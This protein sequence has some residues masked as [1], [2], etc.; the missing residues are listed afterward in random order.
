VG[1]TT[2]AGASVLPRAQHSYTQAAWHVHTVS[3]WLSRLTPVT[4]TRKPKLVLSSLL[5]PAA[6][7][8]L[9]SRPKQLCNLVQVVRQ[10]AIRAACRWRSDH[11]QWSRRQ[12]R[13]PVRRQDPAATAELRHTQQPRHCGAVKCKLARSQSP[14][15]GSSKAVW[16]TSYHTAA[17]RC[18]T[19]T[20]QRPAHQQYVGY[21]VGTVRT[22]DVSM[23]FTFFCSSSTPSSHYGPIYLHIDTVERS[24]M[25]HTA[26]T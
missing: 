1:A 8:P 12:H 2:A 3:F 20:A 21:Q 7:G 11:R 15:C 22:D 10:W 16:M 17:A 9:S 24:Q 6:S 18:G 14:A 13:R 4:C 19:G 25:L 26:D 5:F 23:Q